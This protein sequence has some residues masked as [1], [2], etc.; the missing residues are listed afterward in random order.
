MTS[1]GLTYE[2][3]EM[4]AVYPS[5]ARTV[6]EADVANFAGLSGDFNPLHTDA[7]FAKATPMGERIAH[8][9]LILAMAT[10][11]ANWMGIF[12]GTT[13]ALMEQV[14]RYKGAVKFGDTIRL[15]MEVIEKKPTSKPDKGVVKFAVRVKN[16]RGENVV[17]GEWTLLMKA[18]GQS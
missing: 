12:E 4:G 8:G 14:T 13:I 3:F 17:E 10:G 2:Q 5:Q 7:E 6:T 1:R 15:E 18:V 9:V 16:Q 11:M